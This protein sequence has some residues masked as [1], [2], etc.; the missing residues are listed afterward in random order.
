MI[1][2][3]EIVLRLVLGG[4]LGGVVGFEREQHNRP[5]GFRTHILVCVG[6][7][8]IMLV[9]IYTFTGPEGEISRGADT[10]RIAAQVVSGVG[11]LGAG[12]ILRQGSTIRGLTTAAS[13]WVVAGIGLAVGG[14]FYLGAFTAT[15]VVMVSLYILGNVERFLAQ[16][17]RLKELWVRVIDRPGQ[18]AKISSLIAERN[19]NIH[20]VEMTEPEYMEGY[21]VKAIDITLLLKVPTRLDDNEFLSAIMEMEGVLELSWEG[22]NVNEG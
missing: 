7:T 11:F 10:A 2:P 9:S 22:K 8:L 16:K 12:T 15:A 6:A 21:Q 1:S 18:L 14:G 13:L 4:I 20:K 19:V 5:A 3:F 17:R